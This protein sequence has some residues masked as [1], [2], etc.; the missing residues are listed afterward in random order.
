M[1]HDDNEI[2]GSVPV[3]MSHHY[4][5]IDDTGHII[6]GWSDGPF[7]DRDSTGAICINEQGGYQFRLFPDGEENP[8]LL[9]AFGIPLY[10]YVD[11]EIVQRSQEELDADYDEMTQREVPDVVTEMEQLRA[12]VDY[13]AALTGVEL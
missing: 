7:P 1:D 3:P 8:Q 11:G 5:C 6:T 12:D 10:K 13:I 2:F 9:S 4:I